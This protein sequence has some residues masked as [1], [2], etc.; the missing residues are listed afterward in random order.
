MRLTSFSGCHFLLPQ[1]LASGGGASRHST[2]RSSVIHLYFRGGR[3]PGENVAT[4]RPRHRNPGQANAT[5][6]PPIAG[7]ESRRSSN[8]RLS[9][10]VYC[11]CPCAKRLTAWPPSGQRSSRSRFKSRGTRNSHRPQ[12]C[13]PVA[14]LSALFC[15]SAKLGTSFQKCY[16]VGSHR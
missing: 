14:G 7:V 12:S 15:S 4:P 1:S 5:E 2:F 11:K 13:Y 10:L 16:G 8:G 9:W 3:S 6:S